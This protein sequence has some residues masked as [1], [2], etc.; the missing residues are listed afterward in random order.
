MKKSP[1]QIYYVPRGVSCPICH[2]DKNIKSLFR[3]TSRRG[4]ELIIG[5]MKC[6]EC[7]TKYLTHKNRSDLI[8]KGIYKELRISNSDMKISN[9]Q[10]LKHE[11]KKRCKSCGKY[12]TLV[13]GTEY[14]WECYKDYKASEFD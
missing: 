6:K 5:A 1:D 12:E 11:S 2:Y 14:C 10:N 8:K 3:V 4:E 13:M 9:S 7:G